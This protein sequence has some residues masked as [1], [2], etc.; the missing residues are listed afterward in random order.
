MFYGRED[1]LERLDGLWS[2]S[3]ASLVTCRGRRRIGKSTLI[4]EFARRSRV[5]YI[6]LEGLQPDPQMTNEKQLAAFCRQLEEQAQVS[7][8]K[9]TNWFQAFAE[10]ETQQESVRLASENY[11]VVSDR[12]A[13]QLALITDMLDAT[14]MKLMAELGEV[15]AKINIAL[16]FYKLKLVSGSGF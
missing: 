4:A 7:C 5:R 11:N 12:Y 15:D 16:A 8:G 10:L 2:K 6:K 14:N 3:V 1:L 13:N 9:V